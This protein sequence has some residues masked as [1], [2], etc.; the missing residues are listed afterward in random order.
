MSP[1]PLTLLRIA[2]VVVGLFWGAVLAGAFFPT[3]GWLALLLIPL[4]PLTWVNSRPFETLD[5]ETQKRI[6]IPLDLDPNS[7]DEDPKGGAA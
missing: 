5:R 1:R 3:L 2:D 4:G 7:D 6:S